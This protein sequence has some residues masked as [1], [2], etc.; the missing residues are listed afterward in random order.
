MVKLNEGKTINQA[1]IPL[2]T[3]R[4]KY[5]SETNIFMD[6][7]A[8]KTHIQEY[9]HNHKKI[10]GI[11]KISIV[12]LICAVLIAYFSGLTKGTFI[13]SFINNLGSQFNAKTLT[14]VLVI[15]LIG[16]LF[17]LSVPLEALFITAIINVKANPFLII[18]F[19]LLGLAVSYSLNYLM[20]RYMSSFATKLVSPK[21]FYKIKVML[22][23]YGK[24]VVFLFNVLPLPSQIL[25]FICGVFKYNKLRYASLWL[26]G[27]TV[28]L[29]VIV[30]FRPQIMDLISTIKGIFI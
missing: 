2:K 28:K 18:V 16:G 26:T 23:K 27:W 11:V 21:K 6:P 3:N 29:I 15:G 22:N 19:M 13:D 10:E 20:G 12:I 1:V 14:N 7:E 25:T 17:F 4:F 24:G 30:L 5:F 9:Q 8:L